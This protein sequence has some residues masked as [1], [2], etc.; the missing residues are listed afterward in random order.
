V[1]LL[2]AFL[3]LCFSS[4][5]LALTPAQQVAS[6]IDPAKLATL[7]A[8][9]ANPRVQR[10]V[11]QLHAARLAGHDPA[12]VAVDA[13]A[14]TGMKD[15]AA[16]LTAEA[17]L[18][19]LTIAERLG[20]LHPAGLEEMRQGRAPAVT[21]GPYQGDRLSVDHIIPFSV[22]PEFDKIIANLELMSQRM[23][24]SKHAK[25]GA[26]QEDLLKKLRAAGF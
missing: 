17:M 4:L 15:D 13:V 9:G 2:R 10:Y 18:R 5:A 8:R 24:L 16:R 1:P 25:M 6:L 22:V 23:N 19:N 7:A 26:R 14:L 3:F 11:A 12:Q 21:K 20:C